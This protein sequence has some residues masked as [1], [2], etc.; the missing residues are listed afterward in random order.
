[1]SDQG[2]W[3]MGRILRGSAFVRTFYWRV[4]AGRRQSIVLFRYVY[5]VFA[6][7]RHVKSN[8]PS[9]PYPDGDLGHRHDM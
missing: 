3:S 5:H 1:M 6:A 2:V 8:T 7:Y 9:I 4:E